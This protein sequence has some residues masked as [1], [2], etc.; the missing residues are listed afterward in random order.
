MTE[1]I[2][3]RLKN[4]ALNLVREIADA[5]LKRA[6]VK[7]GADFFRHP[8]VEPATQEVFPPEL[9]RRLAGG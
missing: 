7:L 3:Q 6:G 9:I 2:R 8:A 1:R 5:Q 4:P